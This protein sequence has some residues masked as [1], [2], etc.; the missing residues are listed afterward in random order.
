LEPRGSAIE[1]S[2]SEIASREGAIE[3][4]SIEIAAVASNFD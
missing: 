1:A 4:T 3:A 2:G